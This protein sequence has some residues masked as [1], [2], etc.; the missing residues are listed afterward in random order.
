MAGIKTK[1][2][3]N[4]CHKKRILPLHFQN[5]CKNRYIRNMKKTSEAIIA[6]QGVVWEVLR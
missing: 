6:A 1:F 5:K 2:G 3:E 4:L